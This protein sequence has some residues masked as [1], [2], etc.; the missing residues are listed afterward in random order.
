[1]G[2][3]LCEFLDLE[4]DPDDAEDDPLAQSIPQVYGVKA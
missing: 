3:M 4:R 1:M 2:N